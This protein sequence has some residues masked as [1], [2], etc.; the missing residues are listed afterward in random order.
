VREDGG[1]APGIARGLAR[2]TLYWLPAIVGDL[3]WRAV[4][5][6]SLRSTA[7]IIAMYGVMALL[8]ARARRSNGYASEYDR[9]I[10][11]RVVR[12]TGGNRFSAAL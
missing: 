3:A 11:T 6:P 7:Q 5:G 2:A 10:R 9:L 4:S 12:R 1:G 8:F